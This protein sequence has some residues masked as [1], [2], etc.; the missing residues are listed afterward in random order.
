MIIGRL[1][2][3]CLL[4][5]VICSFSKLKDGYFFMPGRHFFRNNES[6]AG[7]FS[8]LFQGKG[9]EFLKVMNSVSDF[10]ENGSKSDNGGYKKSSLLEIIGMGRLI[11]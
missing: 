8:A 10:L 4:F 3:V 2:D 9:D 6:I 11:L 7:I 5:E 1:S